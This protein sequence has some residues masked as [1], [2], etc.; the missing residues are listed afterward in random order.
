VGDTVMFYDRLTLQPLGTNVIAEATPSE[1]VFAR[2]LPSDVKRFDM[3]ISTTRV[4]SLDMRGCFF[5]NSNSRGAVISAINVS[6]VGNTF[7][8][9]SHP[10]LIFIEGGTGAMAGDYTEGPF[11]ENVLIANNSFLQ[12]ASVDMSAASVSNRASLQ[13]MGCTPIGTCGLSGNSVLSPRPP[14]PLVVRRGGAIRTVEMGSFV[15]DA[16]ARLH[17]LRYYGS[18]LAGAQMGAHRFLERAHTCEIGCELLRRV[19]LKTSASQACTA[20]T[21]SAAHQRHLAAHTQ[22]SSSSAWVRS[23]R[24]RM[25]GKSRS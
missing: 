21:V 1:V 6:I 20:H 14:A 7:A 25:A 5:G 10:G 16:R 12:T 15:G 22:P 8:N 19:V 13:M 2:P 17:A 4:A 11:S 9:L 18:S 24:P 3:F 23:R